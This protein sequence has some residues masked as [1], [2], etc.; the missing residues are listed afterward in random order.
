MTTFSR[1]PKQQKKYKIKDENI[2]YG[3]KKKR[4]NLGQLTDMTCNEPESKV[5]IS[6]NSL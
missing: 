2:G 1:S 6:M 4:H 5:F 3:L